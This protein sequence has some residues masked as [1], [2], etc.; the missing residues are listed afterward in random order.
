VAIAAIAAEH[1]ASATTRSDRRN[2]CNST[3]LNPLLDTPIPAG[4]F[5]DRHPD[6]FCELRYG[7]SKTRCGSAETVLGSFSDHFMTKKKSISPH[8]SRE[9]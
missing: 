9:H 5:K 6:A 4:P 1:N 8:C 7:E 2:A 3:I